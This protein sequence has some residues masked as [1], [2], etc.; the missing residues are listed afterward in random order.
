M[1]M[2]HSMSNVDAVR[3]LADEHH[4]EF[5]DLERFNLDASASSV[6]PVG[7]ARKHHV[8]PIGRKFGAPVVATSNPADVVAMDDLRAVIGRE[9]VAVVASGEQIDSCLARIYGE[10][11]N[12]TDKRMSATSGTKAPEPVISTSGSTSSTT[13]SNHAALPPA[14]PAPSPTLAALPPAPPAPSPTL[15]SSPPVTPSAPPP[16]WAPSSPSPG[17]GDK[18]TPSGPGLASAT[19]PSSTTPVVS[20]PPRTSQRPEDVLAAAL[21][22]IDTSLGTS[23]ADS[24][25]Q[26]DATLGGPA[27][28]EVVASGSPEK[29]R[30]EEAGTPAEPVVEKVEDVVAAADLVDEV[31]GEF[32]GKSEVVDTEDV[33]EGLAG[34]PPWLESWWRGERV[35]LEDMEEVLEE[36]ERSGQ[37]I[38]RILT[39]RGLVTEADLM[40]GMAQEMGLEFVDLEIQTIDFAAAYHLPEAT[41]RHHNVLVIAIRDG[42]PVVAASNPTDVFA[43]DDL[44]TIIGRNFVRVVATRSQISTYIDKAY[45]QG[46]DASEVATAA[47][48]DFEDIGDEG[49]GNI[50]AIVDDAPIVRYVNLLVLQALNERASDIHVEPTGENLRI[51]YRIDGVLHDISTAPR[52]IA[53]A[54]THAPQ[55]HG[56]SQHRRT[57]PSSGWAALAHR[58]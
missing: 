26:T 2:H 46:G 18:A 40:W 4:L 20:D 29:D 16:L 25:T 8:V 52:T 43:M 15:A 23:S 41:A 36:R 10:A 30:S 50:Q 48:S 9:F 51:R 22:A 21:E 47:A 57:P 13:K 58:R 38:A 24:T 34:F 35:S 1:P 14:P 28:D 45:H 39:L 19:S 55:G 7:V 12:G 3:M 42:I 44:R 27:V 11:P 6:I 32:E 17:D 56:R 37:A 53:S 33:P 49:L 54:V 31:V 5:V